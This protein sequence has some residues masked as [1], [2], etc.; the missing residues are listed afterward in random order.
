[1]ADPATNEAV[2][3]SSKAATPQIEPDGAAVA[4][5]SSITST[6]PEMTPTLF[7]AVNSMAVAENA[8]VTN[9]TAAQ[10]S[11]QTP[12]APDAAVT[13][14]ASQT[15]QTSPNASSGPVSS[16]E[17]IGLDSAMNADSAN[18]GTRS[19]NRTGNPRP[20]YA[21]DQEME[22]EYSS[23]A[24]TKKKP[25]ND[26]APAAAQSTAEAKRAQDFARF[27]GNSDGA[28]PKESTPGTPGVVA[29]NPSKKR[30]APGAPTNIT[31]TPPASNSPAP[32]T[33]MRKVA[34][35]STMARETNVLT[36]TKHR[37]CL[38]KKGE[39]IADDG[40]KLCVNG[41]TPDFPLKCFLLEVA[42]YPASH[43]HVEF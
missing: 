26:F 29:P 30:K 27:I 23:A 37:S 13:Q 2:V 32:T 33:A 3:S 35:S 21:E 6:R 1:M 31:Q 40:T 17:L 15:A 8:S 20:N 42:A 22:Y 41:K 19:R 34:A 4:D 25:A 10:A 36:F 43:K 16:S 12:P 5:P 28:G 11:G 38:N 18:Y 9:S 39:L 24:M 14:N 7:Q